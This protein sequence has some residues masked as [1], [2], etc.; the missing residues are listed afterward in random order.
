MQWVTNQVP[1]SPK[2]STSILSRLKDKGI[3][4]LKFAPVAPH[5]PLYLFSPCPL[6]LISK[7]LSL[8][9]CQRKLQLTVRSIPLALFFT[10]ATIPT[11]YR[12]KGSSSHCNSRPNH[13]SSQNFNNLAYPSVG[14]M[15]G[16][17]VCHY[18]LKMKESYT[19]IAPIG[20]LFYYS[21]MSDLPSRECTCRRSTPSATTVRT[22]SMFAPFNAT[23]RNARDDGLI[24]T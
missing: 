3:F 1:H 20:A 12:D 2:P 7:R 24:S 15:V 9:N 6:T 22:S 18:F 14:W 11:C 17:S 23:S 5:S 19:S 4:S 8:P 21:W 16:L 13:L 10:F